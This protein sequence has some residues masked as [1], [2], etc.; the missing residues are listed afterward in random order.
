VKSKDVRSEGQQSIAIDSTF[1]LRLKLS[2]PRQREFVLIGVCDE[3]KRGE[4]FGRNTHLSKVAFRYIGSFTRFEKQGNAQHGLQP[5][6]EHGAKFAAAIK[7]A[8]TK[9]G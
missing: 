9:K 6:N 3:L 1:C 4:D 8:E 5:S 7:S 2:N